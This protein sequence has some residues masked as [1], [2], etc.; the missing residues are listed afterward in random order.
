MTY[1]KHFKTEHLYSYEISEIRRVCIS[2]SIKDIWFTPEIPNRKITSAYKNY[3]S[4]DDSPIA[5]IDSTIFGSAEL[6]MAIGMKGIY[7]K[8]QSPQKSNK[9]FIP[10]NELS[11]NQLDIRI[12]GFNTVLLTE[13]SEF[14][15]SGSGMKKS[16]FI[17]IINEFI[18]A[19]D[20]LMD[21]EETQLKEIQ[22]D[23]NNTYKDFIIGL[24]SICIINNE[25]TNTNEIDIAI[26]LI[27]ED[28]FI[29]NKQEA[30]DELISKVKE[31]ID[32]K[33]DSAAIIKLKESSILYEAEKIKNHNHRE[34][35]KTFFNYI[36]HSS[37]EESNNLKLI[38]KIKSKWSL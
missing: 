35:A 18:Y 7:W 15:L 30:T 1:E 31:L 19:Y 12:N 9:T 3:L 22:Y 26:H 38:E 29:T 13:G 17:F 23:E 16:E 28:Q 36:S 33:K 25:S 5:I 24:I 6:G 20:T 4:D 37:T 8:N 10:W 21:Q 14:D 2:N 34:R 27:N 32:I 11:S